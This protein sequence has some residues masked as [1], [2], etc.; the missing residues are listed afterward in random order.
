[1]KRTWP[2]FKTEM[3]LANLD[4]KILLGKIIYLLD[5]DTRNLLVK[6]KVKLLFLAPSAGNAAVGK[7]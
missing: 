7:C 2:R 1:M 5:P 4:L 6:V 3:L